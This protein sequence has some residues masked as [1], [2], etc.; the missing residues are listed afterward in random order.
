MKGKV[1]FGP[2][3]RERYRRQDEV[4]GAGGQERLKGATVFVAGAG[5][6]G[7]AVLPY[8]AAAGVGT[9]RV[10]D[11]DVVR[12]DNL[13]RQ[14]LYSELDEGK[15]KALRAALRVRNLNP[16]LRVEA[17]HGRI[18][19]A[20]ARDLLRGC[21]AA[22]DAL[23]NFETRFVLNEAAV[24]LGIPLIHGAVLEMSGQVLVVL[25]GKTACLKCVFPPVPA[26]SGFPILGAVC[27]V[28]GSVQAGAV[29]KLLAGLETPE[30]GR[31]LFWDGRRG[32]WDELELRRNPACPVCGER[33][34]GAGAA[35]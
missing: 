14:V 4:L 11:Q 27:G 22:V 6:L 25:P 24:G 1:D 18:E 32:A 5:G 19:P 3:E 2:R 30:A 16:H 34:G 20:N 28:I 35:K 15:P 23:D 9:L 29:V 21:D 31:L 12:L 7:S 17:V 10:Y 13:N 8:L 33:A 26:R